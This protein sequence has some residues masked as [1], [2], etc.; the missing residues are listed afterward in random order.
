MADFNI[1][2]LFRE[3]MHFGHWID[4]ILRVV[5]L[6]FDNISSLSFSHRLEKVNIVIKKLLR[7]LFVLYIRVLFVL[8]VKQ[9]S[10]FNI[11]LDEIFFFDLH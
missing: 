10:I 5:R 4:V 7:Q 3:M 6:A 11:K 1:I 8:E 9:T 2:H